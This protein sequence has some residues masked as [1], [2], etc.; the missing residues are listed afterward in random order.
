M[1]KHRR[2]AGLSVKS[3]RLLEEWGIEKAL[4]SG[5]EV[6]PVGPPYRTEGGEQAR[7]VFTRD[8]E[9][10]LCV[11]LAVARAEKWEVLEAEPFSSRALGYYQRRLKRLARGRAAA[12]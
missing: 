8:D 5:A 2:D 6:V 11:G 4:R 1:T 9:G 3:R 12:D 10:R 7:L